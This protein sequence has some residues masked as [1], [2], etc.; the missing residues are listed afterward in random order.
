MKIAELLP[1][2]EN[3][4]TLRLMA[5]LFRGRNSSTFIF[6]E[7]SQCRSTLKG[8]YLLHWEQILSFKSRPQFWKTFL[9]QGSKQEVMKVVA[10]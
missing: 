1:L 4:F 5:I 8:K 9:T 2:K 3:P 6:C 10:L 7:S